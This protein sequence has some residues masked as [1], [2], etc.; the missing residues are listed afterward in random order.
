MPGPEFFTTE[1]IASFLTLTFLEIVLAG[2]NLVMI[3]ILAGKL[4]PDQ[5]PSARRVGLLAAV[6]TR[7]LLLFSLFWL[8]HLQRPFLLTLPGGA[9]FELTPHDIVLGLGGLFLIWK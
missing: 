1:I 3:A 8:A 2:D 5:R 7:L 6:V 9:T 4:P